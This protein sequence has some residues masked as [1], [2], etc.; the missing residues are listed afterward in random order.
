VN[1][2]VNLLLFQFGWFV[3]VMAAA[4][5]IELLSIIVVINILAVHVIVVR[6]YKTEILLIIATGCIGFA[7]DSILIFFGVFSAVGDVGVEGMAPAWLVALWML[8]AITINHSL[9]WL[10]GNY[11]IAV[12]LGFVFAPVAYFGGHKLGAIIIPAEYNPYIAFLT[13]GVTWAVIM[14]LL[15]AIATILNQRNVVKIQANIR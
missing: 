12:L 5:K 13:I 6:N 11:F 2:L 7:V 10:K 8:F 15:S 4:N 14:P 3:V 1:I 9:N